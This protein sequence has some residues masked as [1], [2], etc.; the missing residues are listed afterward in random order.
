MAQ[1]LGVRLEE[2]HFGV[3]TQHVYGVVK[4]PLD[5]EDPQQ[6]LVVGKQLLV[7]LLEVE[8]LAV[9]RNAHMLGKK[10]VLVGP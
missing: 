9:E 1:N 3:A 6:G 8:P 5:V 7:D 2:L 10:A 4:A